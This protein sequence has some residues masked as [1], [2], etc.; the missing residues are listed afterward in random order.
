MILALDTETTGMA[1]FRG[2]PGDASQPYIVQLGAILYDENRRVVAEINLLVKPA[3]WTIPTEATAVHGIT[4]AMCEKYGLPIITAMKLLL[5]FVKRA[6]LIVAHNFPFD[7]MMVWSEL[8][9]CQCGPEVSLFIE[10]PS[11]CTMEASTPILKLPGKFGNYKWPKLA[12]AF[13]HFTGRELEGAHDAM[14]DVR[15]CATV[16]FEMNPLP[17]APASPSEQNDTLTEID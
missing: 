11:Y 4:T 10:T 17:V 6:K 9:R 15:G 7:K 14:A 13:K 8:M 16:Y 12:E 1:N 5:A 3:G 2:Q